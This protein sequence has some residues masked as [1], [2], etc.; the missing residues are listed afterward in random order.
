MLQYDTKHNNIRLKNKILHHL[1]QLHNLHHLHHYTFTPLNHYTIYI[2][3]IFIYQIYSHSRNSLPGAYGEKTK[4]KV[5]IV[6]LSKNASIW[7]QT[8]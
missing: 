3:C 1:H 8:Q 2:Y 7:Y 4:T 5:T 6:L